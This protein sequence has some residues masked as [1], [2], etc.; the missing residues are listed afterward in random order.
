MAVS[1]R[2]QIHGTVPPKCTGQLILSYCCVVC[3]FYVAVSPVVSLPPSPSRRVV[4]NAEV[5]LFG[6]SL[7]K[8]HV[9]SVEL[10]SDQVERL[11]FCLP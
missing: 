1:S 5:V 9:A 6:G 8:H 4:V 7:G 10:D 11:I 2:K 3:I